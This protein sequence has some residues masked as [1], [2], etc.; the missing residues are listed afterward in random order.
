[1][2]EVMDILTEQFQNTT[3][4]EYFTYNYNTMTFTRLG[5]KYTVKWLLGKFS[6][7]NQS[8]RSRDW[9][10]VHKLENIEIF[11]E[12][13]LQQ[14]RGLAEYYNTEILQQLVSE[15]DTLLYNID[16][17]NYNLRYCYIFRD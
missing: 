7:I 6:E 10:R 11:P 5:H 15:I 17:R 4:D 16:L 12:D 3:I 1:M 2:A 9:L 14:I 8:C 13:E